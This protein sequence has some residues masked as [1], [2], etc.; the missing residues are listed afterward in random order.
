[1]ADMTPYENRY[2]NYLEDD[3]DTFLKPGGSDTAKMIGGTAAAVGLLAGGLVA[4][5]KG[6]MQG[7]MRSMIGTAGKY[8]RGKVQAINSGI[9]KYSQEEGL[10]GLDKAG[11]NLM[12]GK[13]KDTADNMKEFLET[14]R[15]FQDNIKSGM[16]EHKMRME[17]IG[18]SEVID[19]E[20]ELK[21]R[22]AQRGKIEDTLHRVERMDRT[23]ISE[24][25]DIMNDA[26]MKAG[27][28]QT[29]EQA[30]RFK[31]TGFRFAT[32]EDMVL[33][34]EVN[35][36]AEWILDGVRIMENSIK[37]NAE[38]SKLAA[39]EVREMAEK[40]FFSKKVDSNVL[41]GSKVGDSTGQIADLRDFTQ[42]F[43]GF[44]N[45]LTTEF[46]IP[47]IKIN[48]MRMFY[49]DQFFT[50]KA[51]PFF[52]LATSTTKNPI[53]TGHNA[54]QGSPHLFVEGTV[55]N[56][57]KEM[58]DGSNVIEKAGENMF[59]V[60]AQK[61]PVA[62]LLRNMSGISVST[63]NKPDAN[64][65]FLTKARYN[66][67]SAFDIGLQ[68]EPAAQFDFFDPTSWVA[69]AL[70]KLTGKLRMDK[71]AERTDYLSDAYGKNKD[72]IYMRKHKTLSDSSSY[73]EYLGQFKAGR[74]NMEDVTLSTLFPYGFF[75]RLN[76][77]I[78]QMNLGLSNKAQG[79]AFDIFGNLMLK[80]I[81]PIWAGMELWDY[82]NYESENLVGY[83]FEDRFAKMY[84]N[85]SVGLAKVRDTL[86]I[87]D[88]A[89]GVA[90]ILVGG[91]H[92]ADI[93]VLTD[94]VRWN[95]TE[96]ETQK[97][98]DDGE[99][100]VR[101]GRWWS[102]GNTPYTGSNIEYFQPNWVRRVESDYKF[103]DSQYGSRE[104]YFQNSWMPSLRHPFAPIKHFFTDPYHYEEKHYDDRPYMITGGI[105]ELENF[106]LI[107]PFLNA[108]I[109]QL[110]KPQKLMHEDEW[111][112][113]AEQTSAVQT[114]QPNSTAT[115]NNVEVAIG[116]KGELSY[117]NTGE[118]INFGAGDQSFFEGSVRS[119]GPSVVAE[120]SDGSIEA[121][122]AARPI[123]AG[124]GSS[125][126]AFVNIE[127]TNRVLASY[128]TSSGA[129][130][131][132]STDSMDSFFDGQSVLDSKSPVSTGK[133]RVQR[134]TL[135][136][137][138]E[139]E[140][141]TPEDV[142]SLSQMVGNLHY[143]VSEMGGF[144]G[145]MS[146]SVTGEIADEV[147][148][149]Q[150]SSEM[151][152]Y[153]RA[154]WDNDIGGF[155]GDANEIF[156]RFLPADRKLNEI[157]TVMNTMPDW[158]P[159]KDYF[160]DFQSGD[161]YVKVK[162]GEM[163][164]PG[165][166]YEATYGIDSEKLMKLDIGAS[167]IGYDDETV[168]QHMM[169]EDA[170]KEESFMQILNAGT[171]WHKEWEAEMSKTGVAES[172]EQYVKDEEAGIGGYYDL[173]GKHDKVLDWLR[174]E[175]V[176]FTYYKA[177]DGSGDPTF[178]GY[179]EAGVKINELSANKQEMFYDQLV[180]Q[181]SHAIIDPKTRGTKAWENDEMHYENVQQVNFY[182]N[183]MKTN[184]NYLIHV[185]RQDSE[186][187]IKV[188]AFETNPELLQH[189]YGRIEGIREG[190]RGD[191]DSGE[192]NRGNLYDIIDRYRI[193]AD[194]APY[195]NEYRSMKSQL[196]NMGLKEEQ[197]EEVREIN[198]QVSAK[199]EKLRVYQYRFQTANVEDKIV[200]VDH[201]IDSNTFMTKEN[202]DNPIRLAG[203]HVST[204][205]DNPVAAEAQEYLSRI[206]KEGAKIRI[207]VDSDETKLVK[208]D[209][210]K[211]MQAVV[212]N[213]RGLN[214]NRYLIEHDL[215]KEKEN[216]FSA[217]AVHA[218][219][220]QNEIKFGSAWEQFAHM[221]TILHTKLLQV[222]S[223]IES[224]ER[225]EV[226]G[227]DWQDWTDP[228]EDFLIPAIQ[229]SAVHNPVLAIAGGAFVGAAFG[230]LKSTDI[231]GQGIKAMGRY[232][233]IV[234][235][236][237]GASVM[238]MAVLNRL[239]EEAATG[240]RWI[241]ERR[242]KERDTEEYFDVLNYIKSNSL[243]NQYATAAL[244]QEGFDVKEYLNKNE[245][246][247]SGRKYEKDMLEGIKRRLYAARSTELQKILIELK[248][249]NITAASR[250]EAMKMINERLNEI[251][252]HRELRTISPLAA[253][254]LTYH[255]ASKQTMYGYET[256]DPI[257]NF[258]AALPK[259]DRDYLMPFMESPESERERI[260][261]TVPNYMKRTLQ[262]VWGLPVDEKKPLTEYFKGKP[263]PGANW[264]GWR[265]NVSM[266][267]IKVKFV[268]NAGLDPSE[269][270]I[271]DDD[272]VR[273][274][275]SNVKAPDVFNGQESADSYSRKLKEILTGFN[276][277]GLQVDV[278]QSNK[279]GIN[280]EMDID[281]DRQDDVRALINREGY[282]ML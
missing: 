171:K 73:K 188:F 241:P 246:S 100:A 266:K 134:P 55:Y 211:T 29:K 79:S 103:T 74:E 61:G 9:R 98:W 77:T 8:R 227:K 128:V 178:D 282:R 90:P 164:L 245:N 58:K 253:K 247:G 67:Q 230:S 275:Q 51:K 181:G 254:A 118:R 20:F 268:D 148:V 30:L 57:R 97:F 215:A 213:Q 224:Y 261:A 109:G 169:K 206:I 248:E 104:E 252:T 203:L 99:V 153:T 122:P 210:Y 214:V 10:A 113:T 225:R 94:L 91:E 19:T 129:T 72:Y 53:I 154:F 222:R 3:I 60:D 92:I 93:P 59:L 33:K 63:F 136:S 7:V 273:A 251:L 52:H 139:G 173:Y 239:A 220:S 144:Y 172:M 2:R 228:I 4:F 233:K 191:I 125:G 263:L 124:T 276:V 68:D 160:I 168:R 196:P 274:Q 194:V 121:V 120:L 156:R 159:G 182:G 43:S 18:K 207:S 143:N 229:N 270:D 219:F 32:V 192:L 25:S 80:R 185:D 165:E 36:D 56:L 163:R 237:I 243:Y 47:L 217:P 269:F 231:D 48:P 35:R 141:G 89:K 250:E 205:K 75:E 189:S 127:T 271:W 226:Y 218:R 117:L 242:K 31:Q 11:E 199:K 116:S 49:L 277:Q 175:A 259:K 96:E 278:V 24:S 12:K 39:H 14:T 256:G 255:Q 71:Y 281:H 130:S 235:G 201:V 85:S 78:N 176:D 140:E 70:N 44:I 23:R 101:K 187:G 238:G 249:Y 131:V 54:P 15:S 26:I 232:G 106:P 193:L 137:G 152:S 186:K 200:T 114:Y 198:D 161:P 132:M 28:V 81:A 149:I 166:G 17:S 197:L 50:D 257:S 27:E 174:Q 110:L 42:T 86:G 37:K 142:A 155:G 65:P 123:G 170:Y 267:D 146:G 184:I 138:I 234:G 112:T 240:E 180:Q 126:D 88:W 41:I 22:F 264:E 167:F 221:D 204:A 265:E 87:T 212:Y 115:I 83:Q 40:A 157:N 280:V 16:T 179:Y 82:M 202:P 147:P 38:N 111:S 21:Q 145:F 162:K 5:K 76:A 260:L 107:G 102:L 135:P 46:T 223:P 158:L 69:G 279:K 236:M 119:D 183:Q 195:S 84:E 151:S 150:S 66:I 216:D 208:D 64:A 177:S 62:R 95:R 262:S 244:K 13:F 45:S 6:N 190:I 108:T 258:L 272:K 209:T 105:S 34:N 133:F 1:M